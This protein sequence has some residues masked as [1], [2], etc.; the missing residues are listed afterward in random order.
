MT[1]IHCAIPLTTNQLVCVC[2]GHSHLLRNGSFTMQ[3]LPILP[4][5][6]RQN[7][8]FVICY[9]T[10]PLSFLPPPPSLPLS[11]SLTHSLSLSFPLPISLS[12]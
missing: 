2:Y 5:G 1:C 10:F 11:L 12:L 3:H 9:I 7:S 4:Y 8:Y 6:D